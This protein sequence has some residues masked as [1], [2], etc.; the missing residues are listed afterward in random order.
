MFYLNSLDKKT[1]AYIIN[2]PN[3]IVKAISN[4]MGIY[5]FL[6][7]QSIETFLLIAP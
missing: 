6:Q 4:F 2:G 1:P 5:T 3:K 7:M